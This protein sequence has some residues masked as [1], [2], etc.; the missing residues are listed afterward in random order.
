MQATLPYFSQNCYYVPAGQAF[1][2][3]LANP[4]FDTGDNLP[5]QITLV[6]SPSSNPAIVPVQGRPGWSE[7]IFANASFVGSPITAPDTGVLK[8][9]ALAAGTYVIQTMEYGLDSTATL[10]VQ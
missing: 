4:V 3:N 5:T 9:P 7:G 1:T 6:I 8:V 10:V 2:I